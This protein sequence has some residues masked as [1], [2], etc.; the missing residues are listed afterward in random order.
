MDLTCLGENRLLYS[1]GCSLASPFQMYECMG[2]SKDPLGLQPSRPVQPYNEID[3]W[4]LPLFSS[5]ELCESVGVDSTLLAEFMIRENSGLHS[6][7]Q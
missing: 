1:S 6:K 2:R 3:Y 4:K 7:C 5:I